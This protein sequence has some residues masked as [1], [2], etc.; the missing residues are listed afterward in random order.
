MRYGFSLLGLLVTLVC[1]VILMTILMTTANRAITG[2]GSAVSGTV[3]STQDQVILFSLYQS[4]TV[5][6]MD[7]D[8]VFLT[9]SEL[10]GDGQWSHDTTA[11]F[12]SALVAQNYINPEQLISGNEYSPFVEVD[13]DYD[14]SVYQ[15]GRGIHWDPNFQADLDN[16]SNV[17]FAHMPMY[18]ERYDRHWHSEADPHVV[19]FGSRGPKDGIDDP[20]SYTYGQNGQWGGTIVYGD[21]RIEFTTSFTPSKAFFEASGGMKPDNIF[22]ADDGIGGVDSLLAF[23]RK[24][25]E[26]GP[27]LQYD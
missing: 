22:A 25:Q 18:G 19:L 10:V 3:R 15:P 12:Y 2:E 1:I 8:G 26:S 13:E 16:I 9:P 17:S 7:H 21:G 20:T 11:S 23:T 24:M 14:F 5:Q 6:A 4:L 27:E